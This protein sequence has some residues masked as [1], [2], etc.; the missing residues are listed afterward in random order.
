MIATENGRLTVP[1]QVRRAAGIEPGQSLVVYA[2]DGRVI[3]ET[4]AQLVERIRRDVTDS[5]TGTGAVVDELIT[6]RR[7]EAANEDAEDGR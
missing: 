3:I 5:W 7:A 4:R 1:A 2:E 6:E